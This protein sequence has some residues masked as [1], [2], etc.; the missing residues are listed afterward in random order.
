[1]KYC[2][3]CNVNV[4]HQHYN[5]PLCGSYLNENDGNDNCTIYANMDKHINRPKV[6]VKQKTNF[7]QNKFYKL[8]LAICAITVA[9][10]LLVDI[11]NPWSAYVVIG[12]VLLLFCIIFPIAEHSKVQQQIRTNIFAITLCAIAI[13]LTVTRLDYQWVTAYQVLPW[14][15]LASIIVVDFL[16]I[17]REFSQLGLFTTLLYC[18]IFA[19]VPQILLWIRRALDLDTGINLQVLTIFLVAILNIAIVAIICS[20]SIK[21]EMQSR[22][23]M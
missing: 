3:K 11:S 5:C 16:I 6:S 9:I 17:F 2:K 21:E 7:L 14:I 23:N 12:T 8:M 22:L 18:T 10:N 4:N 19:C 13:E 15:Y 20:K 1:M